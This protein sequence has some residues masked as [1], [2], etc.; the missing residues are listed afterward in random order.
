MGGWIR[1]LWFC[2][3]GIL[4]A[5]LSFF[6]LFF[7]KLWLIKLETDVFKVI[8]RPPL[9]ARFCCRLSVGGQLVSR[10]NSATHQK[11][12]LIKPPWSNEHWHGDWVSRFLTFLWQKRVQGDRASIN[13]LYFLIHSLSSLLF[14]APVVS[15]QTWNADA[16]E[17][18]SQPTALLSLGSW[19]PP[20]MTERVSRFNSLFYSFAFGPSLPSFSF[21]SCLRV[22]S[23]ILF[24]ILSLS[25]LF[26][27]YYYVLS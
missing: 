7:F 8:T 26:K 18:Y 17:T 16:G 3:S 6:S 11:H 5:H 13:F 14:T 15:P 23:F 19:M 22:I 12:N 27:K 1:F 10:A 9:K 21:Y 4:F 25:F 2:I 20:Q 24:G